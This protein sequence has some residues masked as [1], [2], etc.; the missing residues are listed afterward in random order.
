MQCFYFEMFNV[1]LSMHETFDHCLI[2]TW[3]QLCEVGIEIKDDEGLTNKGPGL[4]SP[5][6]AA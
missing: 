3:S 2:R 1:L 6:M 5:L 4:V